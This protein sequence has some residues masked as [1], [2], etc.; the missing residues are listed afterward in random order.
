MCGIAG[1]V[2]AVSSADLERVPT[3]L[4][5]LW[6][7]GPDDGGYLAYSAN[8]LETGTAWKTPAF[9]PHAVLLHR[10]LSV[11][12]LSKA[13]WQPMNTPDGRF[14]VVYNGE[15][16]NYRELRKELEQSGRHFRTQTDTEVLLAAYSQWG[17]HALQRFVGMFAFAL[18]DTW[19]QKLLLARDF[20]GIKPLY[21]RVDDNSLTF[22]SEVK[23]LLEF[24]SSGRRPNPGKIYTYLRFGICDAGP[25]TVFDEVKQLPSGHYLEVP[26]RGSFQ[27][28][29]VCYWA[30]NAEPQCD[31]SFSEAAD[32]VR[33]L[34]LESITLHLRSDVP[35][36]V[37][38]S[39]GIDSSSILLAMKHVAPRLELHAISYVPGDLQI[40]EEKWI[41][42]AARSAG[43]HLHKITPCPSDL[44]ADL[45]ALT[46]S[47]D[48]PFGSTSPYAQYCVFRGARQAGITVMLDGQGADEVLAGYRFY[49]GARLAS[50]IRRGRWKEAVDF[51]GQCGRLPGMSKT[52]LMLRAMDFLL[53]S[54]VQEPLRKIIG[55]DLSPRWLNQHW[56]REQGIA[57]APLNRSSKS[58]VLRENL[59]RTLTHTTLPGLLRY[60]DRNS[61]AFSIESRVP[62]LT[63]ELVNFM[64][65]LPEEY[66]LAPDGTSKAV[67][68]AAMRGL[69]PD[70]ILDRRDKIGFASPEQKWLVKLTPW[71]DELLSSE[72]ARRLPCLNLASASAI[73][74][75]VKA[76]T[77]PFTPYVWRWLSLISWTKRFQVQWA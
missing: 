4:E 8:M 54:F 48:E 34:F 63:P 19:E 59:C 44:L 15:I 62:F 70:A 31:L 9:L 3:V 43:A 16:Y 13:G 2:G 45:D 76:G 72:E 61:M 11:L 38:L 65:S 18:L 35:V 66:I 40:S 17:I 1:I 68:R 7:R 55:K 30:P 10:R 50:L 25:D 69:V 46:Y 77:R 32:R 27:V 58:D 6:H 75:T 20:F 24:A 28:D 47:Q 60:E 36:G 12:D 29:P 51:I 21:Y 71:V 52:W 39:G 56:F 37:A 33:D 42:I 74:G 23:A 64:L 5:R 67:F 26:L 14:Y 73:W 49:M 41:E 57:A 22:A 53:P